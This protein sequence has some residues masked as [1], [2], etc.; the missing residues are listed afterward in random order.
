M[1][2]GLAV[3]DRVAD[4][5]D[6]GADLGVVVA[7]GRLIKPPV[8]GSIPFLNIHFSLL[9]RW[10]G[11]APVE[12]AILAGD[13][14]TGVCL[15]TLE[16]G[17]DTGPVHARSSVVIGE[18]ESA[19]ALTERLGVLGTSL[20]IENLAGW[21]AS[22]GEP[23]E[24]EGEAT[25]AA[26]IDPAELEIDWSRSAVEIDRLIRIGGAW[27]TW[28]GRRLIV[29]R[30][31]PVDTAVA[32]PPGSAGSPAPVPAAPGTLAGPLVASGDGALELIEVQGEGRAPQGFSTWAN[33]ARPAE[34]ERFRS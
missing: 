2:L 9:P 22:L 18:E 25:Y 13:A 26:K 7:Y 29:R 23:I 31:R 15:M 21:P 30:A 4:V 19:S 24:Q 27:T 14:E 1:Q 33:G 5:L 11:A 32:L 20:L 17:L 6:S 16:E 3:T 10:R 34:G 8:L 28:R 12:R